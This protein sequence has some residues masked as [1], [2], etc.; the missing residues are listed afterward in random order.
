M[1]YWLHDIPATVLRHMLGNVRLLSVSCR[2]YKPFFSH[3]LNSVQGYHTDLPSYADGL[4]GDIILHL[5][6]YP[7]VGRKE[8]CMSDW[9]YDRN[10]NATAI[11]DG[12]CIRD[13]AGRVAAWISGSNVYSLNGQHIGWFEN[14]V[15]YDSNNSAL[16]FLRNATGLS[17]RP[18]LSG[19]PGTPGFAG[20]PG[21]PGFA[22]TPGRP[23]RGGWSRHD[24]S[25]YI[26]R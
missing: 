22:G 24:L 16:G 21:R 19:T 9:I 14:G 12:D 17:S 18:G 6:G 3:A 8:K 4:K 25:D 11:F 15:I 26:N 5:T 23:G 1:L 2:D 13:D 10:G 7:L 20:R